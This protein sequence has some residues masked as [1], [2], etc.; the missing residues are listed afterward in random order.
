MSCWYETFPLTFVGYHLP[1]LYHELHG[2]SKKILQLKV[3][4]VII[5]ILH[6]LM[7]VGP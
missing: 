4:V 5:Q 3:S 2:P 1:F 7:D 6:K